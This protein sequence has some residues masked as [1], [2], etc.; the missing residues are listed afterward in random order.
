MGLIAMAVYDT[1]KNERTKL[2][3]ETLNS[4]KKTVNFNK[5]RLVIIDNDSCDQTK[6]I[7]DKFVTKMSVPFVTLITNE[8]NVGTAKAINQ[9]WKLRNPGE[10]LVK[11]D[12]DV[13]IHQ[14][15]WMEL[16]EDAIERDP[17]NI[18]QAALK[19]KD[20]FEHPKHT[21]PHYQSELF[22]LPHKPGE[23]WIPAEEVQH[24]M[25]TCV[26]HNWR[27]ID[28]VGGLVQFGVYGFDDSLMS[29]RS[30]LSGFKNIFIPSV[31]ID[32]IDP[33][34]N[35]YQKEKE[36]EAG[37]RLEEF[38]RAKEEYTTGIKDIFHPFE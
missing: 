36:Y 33:G 31:E 35:D 37:L 16:L 11:M 2:T 5:H 20:L 4:L 12:N 6:K 24:C 21:S 14:E 28:K 1:E 18:G 30:R 10:H 19:R 38:Q 29:L 34:T 22:M 3:I 7:L 8:E 26:M 15:N 13:V 25:G 23:R 9:A 17:E 32:H 27:L